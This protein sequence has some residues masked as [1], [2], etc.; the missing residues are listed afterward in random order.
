MSE[1][2]AAAAF[3]LEPDDDFDLVMSKVAPQYWREHIRAL[4]FAI[5]TGANGPFVS[6]L[7]LRDGR[8]TNWKIGIEH[9]G[10]PTK[11]R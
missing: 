11:E 4:A 3:K 5:R 6:C 2:S 10:H 9:T 7:N 8:P 1:T